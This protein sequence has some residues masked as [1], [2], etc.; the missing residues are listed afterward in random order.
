[1]STEQLGPGAD[2][3]E[4]KAGELLQ[5]IHRW[6]EADYRL[7]IGLSVVLALIVFRLL[8]VKS[9]CHQGFHLVQDRE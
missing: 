2:H 5:T 6:K 7:V 9:Q 4:R 3:S 1:M 8:A